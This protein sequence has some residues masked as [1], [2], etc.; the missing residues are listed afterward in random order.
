MTQNLKP[1]IG[2][3]VPYPLG[4][5]EATSFTQTM[6]APLLTG[7]ALTLVGV[8]IVDDTKFRVPELTLLLVVTSSIALIASIQI[9]ADARKY[10]YNRETIAA[11]YTED[12]AKRAGILVRRTKHFI[13]WRKRNRL[14]V[15]VF[16]A[17]TMLLI[18]AVSTALFPRDNHAVVR[19]IASGLTLASALVEAWWLHHLFHERFDE[20]PEKPK[21][22]DGGT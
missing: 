7:A 14:A 21:P 20:T 10:L 17:G 2:P 4:Y 9:G 6:T 11:W 18:L 15:V 16:N 5:A 8:I 12:E 1:E 22:L 19:W 3:R 13:E